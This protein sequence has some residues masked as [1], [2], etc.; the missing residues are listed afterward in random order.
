MEM[1]SLETDKHF[2]LWAA[3]PGRA[4]MRRTCYAT[5]GSTKF[6]LCT[7]CSENPAVGSPALLP[8]H[9]SHAHV[10]AH[11]H[12]RAL[13]HAHT[14][15]ALNNASRKLRA[16]LDPILNWLGMHPSLKLGFLCH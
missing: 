3:E 4:R 14:H 12:T 11:M 8:D 2:W 6:G 16:S 5:W 7:F 13:V 1:G 10:H 15:T 9:T